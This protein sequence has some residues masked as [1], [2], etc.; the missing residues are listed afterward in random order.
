M[1]KS[2]DSKSVAAAMAA[3]SAYLQEEAAALYAPAEEERAPVVVKQ[4]A[5]A[6]R[7]AQLHQRTL[8]QLR[9]LR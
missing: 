6:G 7:A 8:M 3:V 5:V 4:W 9:A 1:S 2:I